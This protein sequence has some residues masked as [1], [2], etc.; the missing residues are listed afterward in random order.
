MTP[1]IG[2][3]SQCRRAEL[4]PAEPQMICVFARPRRL[5]PRRAIRDFRACARL[6]VSFEP[7]PA[8]FPPSERGPH[9]G[10]SSRTAAA[11]IEGGILVSAT[12]GRAR[13]ASRSRGR[14]NCCARRRSPRSGSSGTSAS[15]G[16]LR[17]DRHDA[18]PSLPRAC[19]SA[20]PPGTAAAHAGRGPAGPSI[21]CLC[22]PWQNKKRRASQHGRLGVLPSGYHLG[23]KT[24]APIDSHTVRY[25]SAL[26]LALA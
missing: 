25:Q 26:T 22:N 15:R 17:P 21:V 6:A 9:S 18:Q 7:P 16:S 10:A 8:V 19:R 23:C 3:G 24:K 12:R 13:S 20:A 2:G 4:R 11:Q 5:R 14:G 1:G